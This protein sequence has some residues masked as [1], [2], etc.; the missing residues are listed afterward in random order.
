VAYSGIIRHCLIS[1]P[2]DVEPGDLA[3]IRNQINRWNGLYGRI[4]GASIIPISWGTH[5]AAEFG[6]APQEIINKQLVDRCDMCIAV[7]AARLGTPT[8]NA[9]S[10]TA[11][12]IER[13]ANTPH[14]YVGVLRSLRSIP[15]NRINPRQLQRLDKYLAKIEDKSLVMLYDSDAA[16]VER[17]DAILAWAASSDQSRST[18]ELEHRRTADVWPRVEIEDKPSPS[19][20]TYRNWNLVLTNRGEGVARNI[21]LATEVTAAGEPW[22]IV[23]G[24]DKF[25]PDVEALGPDGADISF[26]IAASM[27]SAGQIRC[28]VKW[29]DEAGEHSNR[30]TLRLK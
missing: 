25:Q 7:F 24:T 21:Y 18:I 22:E 19:G 12:E 10:G 6:R 14:R 16:L 17:V 9:E 15:P 28:I 2:G 3:I 1:A 13:L 8:K 27:V 26:P 23:T 29:T 4:F 5:A 20:G 30:A 11:E